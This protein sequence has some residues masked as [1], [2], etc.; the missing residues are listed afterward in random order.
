MRATYTSLEALPL[1]CLALICH[2]LPPKEM[3]TVKVLPLV[4]AKLRDFTSNCPELWHRVVF[5][6]PRAR[7]T[8]PDRLLGFHRYGVHSSPKRSN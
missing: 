5:R 4:C 8:W 6:M 7:S 2:H 3:A 1:E